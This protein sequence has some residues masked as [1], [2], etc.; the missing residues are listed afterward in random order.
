M[1]LAA[2][3]DVF[4][5]PARG[6]AKPTTR[7]FYSKLVY[8]VASIDTQCIDSNLESGR[9]I[10]RVGWAS[11]F[12][13]LLPLDASVHQMPFSM[14]SASRSAGAYEN[15]DAISPIR[16]LRDESSVTVAVLNAIMTRI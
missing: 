3:E 6:W 12:L 13:S 10:S 9:Y 16:T 15:P 7:V 5:L 4:Y 8:T 11:R 14:F 1:A 2:A